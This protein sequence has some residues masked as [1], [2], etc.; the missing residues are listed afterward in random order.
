V[1][2][3]W[4][5]VSTPSFSTDILKKANFT[6]TLIEI[7]ADYALHREEKRQ[8]T[9][10][11]RE[12]VIGQ[13]REY[14]AHHSAEPISLE[15]LATMVGYSS[16][17]LNVLFRKFTGKS[18]HQHLLEVRLNRAREL[19]ESGAYLVSQAAE[20]VGFED[21]LYFSKV[22]RRRFGLKPTEIARH[23]PR[24]PQDVIRGMP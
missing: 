1:S 9:K 7:L 20:S 19:L 22:F 14:I 6:G 2:E 18:L 12:Q 3:L 13:I 8:P 24:N 10:V 21:P 5:L 15:R 11:Y 4:N 23:S 17:H 16:G